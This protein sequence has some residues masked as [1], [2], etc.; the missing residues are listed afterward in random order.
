MGRSAGGRLVDG[1]LTHDFLTSRST[2]LHLVSKRTSICVR[3]PLVPIQSFYGLLSF[4]Q[5]S[6][7]SRPGR[8][9]PVSL[10]LFSVFDG[11]DVCNCQEFGDGRCRVS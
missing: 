3:S 10:V 6:G 9:I 1:S 4:V 8:P 5:M 7:C 2:R 11:G